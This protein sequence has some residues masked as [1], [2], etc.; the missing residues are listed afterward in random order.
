MASAP[1]KEMLHHNGLHWHATSLR[2]WFFQHKSQRKRSFQPKT[3][4]HQITEASSA[5]LMLEGEGDAFRFQQTWIL[6]SKLCE[7]DLVNWIQRTIRLPKPASL[8]QLLKA[9][10]KLFSFILN[11]KRGWQI[12]WRRSHKPENRNRLL[13]E[14][15]FTKP[16]LEGEGD[17]FLFHQ[18]QVFN[19]KSNEGDSPNQ[20]LKIASAPEPVARKLRIAHRTVEGS[21]SINPR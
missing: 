17:S 4:S 1:Q 21:S 20:K 15:S 16:T 11:A 13:T 6:Y 10:V 5:Y 14:T 8:N 18:T 9:R 7:G 2:W 12:T 3:K 19:G